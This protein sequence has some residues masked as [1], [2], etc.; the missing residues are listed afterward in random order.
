MTLFRVMTFLLVAVF[1]R[2]GFSQTAFEQPITE[3]TVITAAHVVSFKLSPMSA[4]DNG[5]G[6][7]LDLKTRDGFRIYVKKFYIGLKS[8]TGFGEPL[9]HKATPE[10]ES[11]YDK[12]YKE[13]REIY[14]SGT[15]FQLQYP[16][17]M[18]EEDEIEVHFE[19]C[20]DAICLAPAVFL[21]KPFKGGMGEL[22]TES[23]ASTPFGG[24]ESNSP[25]LGGDTTQSGGLNVTSTPP[26]VPENPLEQPSVVQKQNENKTATATVTEDLEGELSF[27][28]KVQMNLKKAITEGS[29]SIY[30]WLLLGGLLVNLT[31]CVYPMIPITLNVMASFGNQAGVSESVKRRRRKVM[32]FIYVGGMSLTYSIIGVITILAGQTFGSQMQSIWVNLGIALIMFLLG[33]AM[34]GKLSLAKVQEA[35]NKVPLS[36][37]HPYLGVAVMGA[38]SGLVSAPCTGPVLVTILTIIASLQDPVYGFILMLVFSLGLGLPY[39]FLGLATQNIT[40]MPRIGALMDS[41]KVLFASLIFA[42]STYYLKFVLDS[43]DNERVRAFTTFI[44]LEVSVT[45][46][47]IVAVLT[48]LA[49]SPFWKQ[50][51]QKRIANFFKSLGLYILALW[52]TLWF[53]SSFIQ[54]PMKSYAQNSS[55]KTSEQAVV[56]VNWIKEDWKLAHVKAQESGKPILV[57]L[58]AE[59]CTACKKMDAELWALPEV[60]QFIH[61]NFT[62]LKVNYD[63]TKLPVRSVWK[64]Q[65]LPYLAVYYPN[66]NMLKDEPKGRVA[67]YRSNEAILR[68]LKKVLNQHS[69]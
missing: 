51:S 69:K 35:G 42:L 5:I 38:V 60:G 45:E 26:L 15:S 49:F 1:A 30:L 36:N 16:R 40:R 18:T 39:I 66:Q 55:P 24:S 44:F 62:P 47:A 34:L 27:S 21:I 14:N 58:W 11:Y 20:S 29:F 25:A 3:E 37:K 33:L 61:D 41:V 59:W 52:L 22:A 56:G 9:Q 63:E 48:L 13:N 53:N 6:A 28:D 4:T 57:D 2:S 43:V 31:P 8:K 10:A 23:E 7:T 68:T 50:E 17:V 67:G 12:W 32:P 54:K 46:V 19:S 65:G 64:V